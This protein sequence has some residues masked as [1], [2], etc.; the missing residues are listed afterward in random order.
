M[1][2]ETQITAEQGI[3]TAEKLIDGCLAICSL[4]LKAA[5]N[6]REAYDGW[7]AIED[8]AINSYCNAG[9]RNHSSAKR[10]SC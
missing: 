9:D 8:E 4:P 7:M 6:L 10:P 1:A 5:R 2:I 3:R